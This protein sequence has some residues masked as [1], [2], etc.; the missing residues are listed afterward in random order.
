MIASV[1]QL[2]TVTGW[3][4]E[5]IANGNTSLI[6]FLEQYFDK[7]YTTDANGND[8][9]TNQT[10]ILSG[11][12]RIHSDPTRQDHFGQPNWNGG[13]TVG[14]CAVNVI[15]MALDAA[16]HDGTMDLSYSG[17]DN[18]SADQPFN[19]WVNDDWDAIASPGDVGEDVRESR[20]R[21]LQPP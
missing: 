12:R 5:Q 14:Q 19:F 10:G 11:V 8:M 9:T 21:R 1:G 3:A 18:T 6:G 2:F 16:N 20:R 4:K 17:P 15:K 7:A 13:N